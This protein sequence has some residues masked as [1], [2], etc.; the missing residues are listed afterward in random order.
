MNTPRG[1]VVRNGGFSGSVASVWIAGAATILVAVALFAAGKGALLR[2]T[3]PAGA[4]LIAVAL[5]FRRPTGYLHFTLWTW[6]LAPLVRR[7][8]D[9]RFG[10]EEPN[11]VLLAPLLVSSVAG[12]SLLRERDRAHPSQLVPFLLCAAGILY[13][14]AVGLVRWRFYAASIASPPGE[15]VFGLFNWLA[16]LL[17]GLHI[18]LRWES[19]QKQKEAIQKSFLYAVL[20]LGAYGI[21]QELLPPSWDIYWL[22]YMITTLND[23]S[24]GRPEAM[25]LRIWSTLNAPAPFASFL[26]VGLLIT[27]SRESRLKLPAMVC[28]VLSLLLTL[29]RTAWLTCLIAILAGAKFGPR[30]VFMRLALVLAAAVVSIALLMQI[31]DL[32]AVIG[33]RVSTFSDLKEDISAQD[34]LNMYSYLAVDLTQ[35]PVGI[36]L[37][38]STMYDGYALDSGFFRLFLNMGFVGGALFLLGACRITWGAL[39]SPDNEDPFLANNKGITIAFLFQMV[40]GEVFTGLTGALLWIVLGSCLASA[41]AYR[42]SSPEF[43][44][45]VIPCRRGETKTVMTG[46]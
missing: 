12:I 41:A 32:S 7:V 25:Q 28:G 45:P 27:L 33:D 42:Q 3:V 29:I 2:C 20:F 38:N 15:I 34:R 11:F 40:G 46:A 24:F 31:P 22:Q 5:Y 1:R 10:F 23:M 43:E 9:Y 39:R 30:K 4:T 13:G 35:N 19:Y 16:P 8:I 6:F 44:T 18:Y 21:F 26:M 37:N 36:G 17:L 14:F